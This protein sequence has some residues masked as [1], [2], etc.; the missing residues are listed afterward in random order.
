MPELLTPK[1]IKENSWVIEMPPEITRAAKVEDGSYLVFHVSEGAVSAEILP[2]AT[3]E[4]K[5]LVRQISDEFNDAF[6]EMKR[7]GD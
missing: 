5:D 1:Q 7:L 3:P 6:A 4:I 2:P